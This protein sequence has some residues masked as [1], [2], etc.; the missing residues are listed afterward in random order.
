MTTKKPGGFAALSLERRR[1]IAA[2]GGKAVPKEKRTF[3]KFPETAAKAGSVGGK[4][5][6]AEKRSFSTD[7]SFARECAVK[8]GA[9][10]AKRKAAKAKSSE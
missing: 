8:G 1:K 3:S 5:V 10:R 4:A 6:P 2:M 7:H 9:E